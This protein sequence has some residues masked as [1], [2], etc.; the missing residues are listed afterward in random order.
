MVVCRFGDV[1]HMNKDNYI[2]KYQL[3][4]AI[5]RLLINLT[6]LRKTEF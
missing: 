3:F 6:L 5:M 1:M 4:K 2:K